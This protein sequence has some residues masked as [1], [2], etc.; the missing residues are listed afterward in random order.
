MKYVSVG[1]G[2]IFASQAKD[3]SIWCRF[4]MDNNKPSTKAKLTEKGDGWSKI[5]NVSIICPGT[6]FPMGQSV[7]WESLPWDS[8]SIGRFALGCFALGRLPLIW[9]AKD[10]FP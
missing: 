6:V 1:N 8:L 9:L 5:A 2:G 7:L 3:D 10:C 4:F